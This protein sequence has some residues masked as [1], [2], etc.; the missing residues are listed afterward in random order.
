MSDIFCPRC[1]L[2]QP[3]AHTYC[4]RCGTKLPV[5]L[6]APKPKSARFFAGVKVAEQDPEH[7]YLRVTHYRGTERLENGDRGLEVPS[8]HVRFSVWI[9][10]RAS[11]VI[12]LPVSEARELMA[13]LDEELGPETEPMAAEVL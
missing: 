7:G 5:A 9:G 11:C 12:S 10:D 8:E 4:A 1:R 13:F 3:T 6:V 2:Q